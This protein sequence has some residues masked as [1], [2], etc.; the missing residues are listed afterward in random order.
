M[1][2]DFDKMKEDLKKMAEKDLE[3]LKSEMKNDFERQKEEIKTHF[4]EMTRQIRADMKRSNEEVL[5]RVNERDQ[6]LKTIAFFKAEHE[7]LKMTLPKKAFN[8][9]RYT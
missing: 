4:E 9:E 7:C 2:N 1:Q 3:D 5:K 6:H 8:E